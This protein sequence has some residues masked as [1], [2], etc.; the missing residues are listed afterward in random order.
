[1]GDEHVVPRAAPDDGAEPVRVFMSYRRADDPHFIGRLHDRLCTAFGDEMVFRDIDS[2]PAGSNFRTVIL[3]T[4]NEVDAVVAVIG[5]KWIRH[6]REHDADDPDYVYLE[7]AEALQQ[8][9]PVIPTLIENTPMPVADA[10]PQDLRL[11]SE[12]NAIS[13]HGDPTFRR[14]SGRLIEVVRNVVAE[15]RARVMRARHVDE[16]R[17]R[18]VDEERR[19][20][21]RLADELRAEER[22]ARA[23][24][25]EL[26]E[27][28]VQRQIELERARLEA[29]AERRRL[30]EAAASAAETTAPEPIRPPPSVPAA[31]T[32][33]VVAGPRP[34]PHEAEPP[35]IAPHVAEPSATRLSDPAQ[36][37]RAQAVDSAATDDPAAPAD[38]ALETEPRPRARFRAADH[39]WV[40]QLPLRVLVVAAVLLGIIALSTNRSEDSPFDALSGNWRIDMAA[41]IITL[42]VGVPLLL[43]RWPIEQRAVLVGTA[44]AVFFFQFLQS[45]AT[46]RYGSVYPLT[47]GSWVFVYVLQA[48]CL[49]LAL[50]VVRRRASRA[51]PTSKTVRRALLA[52]AILSSVLLT[53]AV[54]DEWDQTGHLVDEGTL[55][56]R[57]SVVQW[58]VVFALGPVVI[59]IV[60]AT[61]R[62]Y[63][64]RLALAVMASLGVVAYLAQSSIV[65]EVWGM[66]GTSWAIAAVAHLALAALAWW[67]IR[68]RDA[69]PA[70]E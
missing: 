38:T 67:T 1:M 33:H 47:E 46:V 10:L 32:P 22:A 18:R 69:R 4:L 49:A 36:R 12:I 7:L 27:A 37:I 35:E 28:A 31:A 51:L 41:W 14:D 25:A 13:V 43:T 15:E 52:L 21:E 62:S 5:P 54:Y 26:E 44:V 53:L 68:P 60:L 19:E 70:E 39:P 42:A 23:R 45:S 6:A 64:A 48:V 59:M 57:T 24:L 50:V 29:I 16:E 30:A 11:L 61:R 66:E 55:G 56:S 63:A 8:H 58:L 3:R 2:I 40:K 65:Y 20:R 34:T 17:A 9:K